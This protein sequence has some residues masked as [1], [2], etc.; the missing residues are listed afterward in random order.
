MRMNK[1]NLISLLALL[2]F[3]VVLPLYAMQEPTR[4]DQARIQLRQRYL[5]DGANLYVENCAQCH[6]SHGEGLGTMPALSNPGLADADPDFLYKTIARASH[7]TT[8]A[9]W[10]IEEG[11]ILNDFQIEELVTVIRFGDWAQIGELAVVKNMV[12]TMPDA[13]D[14]QTIMLEVS[15]L[16]PHQ[17]AACHEEPAIHAD[18]FGLN[19]A[20]CHTTLA[21]KPA[22]LTRHVFALDHGG[23]GK[24]ACVTCHTESYAQNTCYE[25]HDH[26]PDEMQEVHLAENILD[27][28]NCS[29]CHPT[30]QEGEGKLF[31]S[32]L[33]TGEHLLSA[34]SGN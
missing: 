10:H 32:S 5:D 27:F 31:I 11:G 1:Y 3:V 28:E 12:P 23:Q 4:M 16:D 33:F 2:V 8:M 21:W 34:A 15:E 22:L 24:V 9:A 6:G 13:R 14:P 29:E 18:L 26:Q 7:G 17:C 30:G 19:C 25:C 20:R